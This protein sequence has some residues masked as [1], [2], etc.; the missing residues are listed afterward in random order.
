MEKVALF[1]GAFDPPTKGHIAVCELVKENLDLDVLLMPCGNHPF[2]K[3]MAFDFHR[4]NMCKSIKI[5]G[6]KTSSFDMTTEAS[7]T[8]D[9][10]QEYVADS[11][12]DFQL[13]IGLDNANIILDKWSKGSDLIE[14]Y[15]F[16]VMGRG[17]YEKNENDWFEQEPHTFIESNAS[18]SSTSVREAIKNE[19][20]DFAREN[21]DPSVWDYVRE[22]KLYGFK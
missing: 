14:K 9:L 12:Y 7:T 6:I 19:N 4:L 18:H 13:I 16:I 11:D 22:N 21:L 3:N 17:G 15:P 8:Y 1:G 20:Y 2:E 5:D 10:M